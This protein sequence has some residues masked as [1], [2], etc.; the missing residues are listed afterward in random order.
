MRCPSTL[1]LLLLL[2][3]T[4]ER[5]AAVHPTEISDPAAL[6]AVSCG[7]VRALWKG[8]AV[9]G[10]GPIAFFVESLSFRFADGTER[11]FKPTGTVEPMH[12]SFEIFSPDCKSVALAQDSA[13]PY[14]LVPVA[15]LADYLDGK[16]APTVIA[17]PASSTAPILT[18]QRWLDANRFEFFASCCGGVEVFDVNVGAAQK[19]ERVFFAPQAPAGIRRT[20][21]GF[22]V[23]R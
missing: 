2:S 5:A 6:K 22:E 15:A 13:G 4:A 1:F 7:D 3:C 8:R 23:V 10:P 16:R 11:A 12:L 9:D 20:A 19:P 21:G 14:H 17:P 18:E